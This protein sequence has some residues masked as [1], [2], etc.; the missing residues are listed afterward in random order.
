MGRAY[1]TK[2]QT[3]PVVYGERSTIFAPVAMA[4]GNGNIVVIPS[5]ASDFQVE[6]ICRAALSEMGSQGLC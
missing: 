1:P 6:R 5:A 3:T 4:D 2:W